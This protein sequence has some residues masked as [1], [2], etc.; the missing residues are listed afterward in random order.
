M[1]KSKIRRKSKEAAIQPLPFGGS[2]KDSGTRR[3]NLILT[4]VG[5]AAILV[6]GT[7][8]WQ[9]HNAQSRFD[10]L[11]PDGQAALQRVETRADLGRTHLQPGQSHLYDSPTPTSGP[12]DPVWTNTGFY[13]DPQRPTQIVHALE[14]GNIVI[15]YDA[16]E[17]E[18]LATLKDWAGLYGGQ[19]DGLVVTPHSGLGKTIVMTAWRKI[20]RLDTFDPAAAAAFIDAYRGRGPEHPVR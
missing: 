7:W 6:V 1:P 12:H 3:L 19:W 2:G 15:Y 14:H 18:V 8:W 16:P 11:I 13:S 9:S 10:A 20:L 5:V 4:V 17:T